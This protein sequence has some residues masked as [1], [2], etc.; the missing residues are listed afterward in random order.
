[1]IL[2]LNFKIKIENS[3]FFILKDMLH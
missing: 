3:L 1:M 2:F